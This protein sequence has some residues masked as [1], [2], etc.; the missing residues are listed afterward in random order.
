MA[1]AVTPPPVKAEEFVAAQSWNSSFT[2]TV[3]VRR[4]IVFD[5]WPFRLDIPVEYQDWILVAVCMVL[6][7]IACM[8][9]FCGRMH[10]RCSRAFTRWVYTRLHVFFCFV[11]YF[12]LLVLMFT[13][14][15]LPDWTV[16][17]FLQQAVLFVTWVLVHLQ[18]MIVSFS[19]LFGLF[20]MVRF[21]E[22]LL[23][24]AGMEHVTVIRW[25]WRDALGL[26][27]KK[28]PVEVFIWKVEGLLSSSKKL[29]ANDV[30]VECH[31]G[32]NEPMRTR[33]HNNAGS[34]CL[35][36]ESFQL[37]IDESAA[38]T[39]MTLLVKDQSLVASTEL[40]RLMLSTRE[41]CGIEDQT[42]KR[43][44]AFEYSEECFVSLDLSPGGKIWI[45]IAPVEDGE[46][47]ERAPLIQEDSLLVTC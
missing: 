21:R 4:G 36:R 42:G 16:N 9:C 33:V 46:A 14:G 41:L 28:R 10:N 45:A 40:A 20:L 19:I 44:V 35:V 17:E 47:D 43:R 11:I 13:I 32:H 30:F 22:R 18:K 31:M 34:A 15:V 29:K 8:P 38:S 26:R 24:A 6:V 5:K 3:H 27:A 39:L 2:G 12:D 23:L 25:N 1:E 37:N 7:S